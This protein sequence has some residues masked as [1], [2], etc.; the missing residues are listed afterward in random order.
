[1]NP[2]T[3][4]AILLLIVALFLSLGFFLMFF[5]IKIG[6][7]FT[8]LGG[9]LALFLSVLCIYGIYYLSLSYKDPTYH[10]SIFILNLILLGVFIVLFVVG[11][12]NTTFSTDNRDYDEIGKISDCFFYRILTLWRW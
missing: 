12:V 2:N 10:L 3:I 7:K 1:M 8:F 4:F 6:E 11:I 9:V 5:R